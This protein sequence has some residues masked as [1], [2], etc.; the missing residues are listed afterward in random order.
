MFFCLVLLDWF[1]IFFLG[2]FDFFIEVFITLIRL[3]FIFIFL[4]LV[5]EDVVLWR[6][7]IL[8]FFKGVIVCVVLDFG[9]KFWF[10]FLVKLIIN[11]LLFCGLIFFVVGIFFIVGRYFFE[12]DCNF[13]KIFD[14]SLT[15]KFFI[16]F[17]VCWG[18]FII[19]FGK[20]KGFFKCFL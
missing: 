16:F 19:W 11:F 13:E 3:I 14:W 8:E 2:N 5:I 20:R 10:F 4:F 15:I 6:L 17:C 18:F 9:L 7:D 12:I 1:I